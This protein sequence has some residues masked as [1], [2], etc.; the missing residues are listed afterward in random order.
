MMT[1]GRLK[2]VVSDFNIPDD[3]EIK[4]AIFDVLNMKFN[5]YQCS[6]ATHKGD[7]VLFDDW[8]HNKNEPV[9]R[10]V[11]VLDK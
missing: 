3:T 7:L 1:V 2:Q 9:V 6:V 11:K 4:T 10:P 5:L 8:E